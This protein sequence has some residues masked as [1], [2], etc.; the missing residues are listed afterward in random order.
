MLLIL[1]VNMFGACYFNTHRV[2]VPPLRSHPLVKRTRQ[3]TGAGKAPVTAAA[4]KA[5]RTGKAATGA[6][7][8]WPTSQPTTHNI[9][10]K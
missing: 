9:N 6:K 5:G 8:Q 1:K 2:Q 4:R 7:C 3:A 10:I